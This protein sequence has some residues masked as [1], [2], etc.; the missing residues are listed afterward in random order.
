MSSIAAQ[1]LEKRKQQ[2]LKKGPT[3][4]AP[5]LGKKKATPSLATTSS[6]TTLVSSSVSSGIAPSE[7]LETSVVQLNAS[8]S[9]GVGASS[10]DHHQ[11][12]P[13]L[14]SQDAGSLIFSQPLISPQKTAS[15]SKNTTTATEKKK[16]R[17]KKRKRKNHEDD[18]EYVDDQSSSNGADLDAISTTSST[19]S[20]TSTKTKRLKK[21][22]EFKTIS[23]FIRDAILNDY[24]STETQTNRNNSSNANTMQQNGIS[25]D[26]F[27]N[28]DDYEISNDDYREKVYDIELD[29]NASTKS[30]GEFKGYYEP[31]KPVFAHTEQE[32]NDEEEDEFE[33]VFD[34]EFGDLGKPSGPSIFSFDNDGNIRLQEDHSESQL[35][36][37]TES[38]RQEFN[39]SRAMRLANLDKNKPITQSTYARKGKGDRWTKDDVELFYD[40]LRQFGSDFSMISRLFPKRTRREIHQKYKS[41]E[42]KNKKKIE[43]ALK[44]RAPIDMTL[45]QKKSKEKDKI[46]GIVR[47]KVDKP[48]E[49]AATASNETGADEWKEVQTSKPKQTPKDD[50]DD[51]FFDDIDDFDPET[52]TSKFTI[53]NTKGHTVTLSLNNNNEG[54][55]DEFEDVMPTEHAE[56]EEDE[57][58]SSY[59][60]SFGRGALGRGDDDFD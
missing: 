44:N 5:T 12:D 26:E 33:E 25:A 17:E 34:D 49:A 6:S 19:S 27:V 43:F 38:G 51:E 52:E 24:V 7:L 59:H 31:I 23:D 54:D 37:V 32:N 30:A 9:S 28:D 47:K 14:F 39:Y 55:A 3:V 1:A 41:E 48:E 13:Q 57:G 2:S 36:P 15:P 50:I 8:S 56:E 58:I 42:K 10:S 40:G 20:K 46:Q 21:P 16:K 11:S 22:M 18:E 60:D 29:D 53:S 35:I 4:F 45:F